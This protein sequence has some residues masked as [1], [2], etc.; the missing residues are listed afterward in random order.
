MRIEFAAEFLT[1]ADEAQNLLLMHYLCLC[2][3]ARAEVYIIH[4]KKD[5]PPFFTT[6]CVC[7]CATAPVPTERETEK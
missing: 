2:V 3:C 1:A 5:P 7:V 6:E 4:N